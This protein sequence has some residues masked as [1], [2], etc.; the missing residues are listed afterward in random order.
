[1]RRAYVDLKLGQMHYRYGGNGEPLL[2]IHMAAGSSA[3][4]EA[5][6]D[7]LSE[8][9]SVYALDLF[10]C[11]FSD[12]LESYLSIRE[13]METILEFMDVMNI[14]AAFCAGNLV[15]GN[16]CARLGAMHPERVKGLFLA[17]VVFN[18]DP[19][20]FPSL[21]H[22]PV[23]A[24]V[25]PTD[26]GEHLVSIWEKA[27]RYG[28]TPEIRDVR[29]LGM[30]LAGNFAEGMHWA[31]CED[32]DFNKCLPEIKAS[33]TVAVYGVA[34]VGGPM[35]AEAAKI[36]PNAKTIEFEGQSLF[37]SIAA[38]ETYASAVKSSFGYL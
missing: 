16:I 19:N 12:K 20:F 28:E 8:Q 29:A 15:G 14:K 26:G 21:R 34:P 32:S 5:S 9:F 31:L 11:G 4:F 35:P 2:L 3:E 22:N 10:N 6:G 24:L 37:V 18:P 23:F 33:T 17:G 1:M 25:P 13:H 36:I 27:S 30:Y 7:M 38:P